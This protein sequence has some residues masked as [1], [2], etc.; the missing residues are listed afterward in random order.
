MLGLSGQGKWVRD[1][2]KNWTDL[3]TA[4]SA[5]PLV[6]GQSGT[7]R[8]MTYICPARGVMPAPGYLSWATGP[9]TQIP[10]PPHVPDSYHMKWNQGSW[11]SST[12]STPRTS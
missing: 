3:G 2:A 9:Y 11:T 10:T 7:E 6:S 1:G 4:I 12:T 8:S 5:T